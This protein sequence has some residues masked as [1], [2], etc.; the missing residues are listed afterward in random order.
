MS[1]S[2]VSPYVYTGENDLGD[3]VFGMKDVVR[4]VRISALLQLRFACLSVNRQVGRVY[5]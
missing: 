3:R 5:E 2:D 4:F 1:V